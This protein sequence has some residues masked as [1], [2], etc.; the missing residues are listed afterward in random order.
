MRASS[1]SND[2]VIDLLN[3]YFVPVYLS[4]E[5]LRGP[6]GAPPE[7]RKEVQRIVHEALKAKLSA[8]TVHAYVVAPDG[9]CIDSQH[10]ATAYKPEKLTEMLERTVARL[11]L[12]DGKSLVEPA[13]QSKTPACEAGGLVLHLVARNT[14]R[15]GDDDVPTRTKLGQAR[16]ANW[17]SYAVENWIV[18]SKAES[19]KL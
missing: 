18:L 8:G 9:P 5:D 12:K 13:P 7:E 2:K 1:L 17:G 10:V 11:K 16:S 14:Q 15:K 19:Q 4:N 3:R 6:G